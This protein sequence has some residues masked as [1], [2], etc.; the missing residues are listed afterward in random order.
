MGLE[1]IERLCASMSIKDREGPV[2]TLNAG[3]KMGGAQKMALCLAGKILSPDL[4]NMDAFRSLIARIWKVRG[5]VEI[6]VI[7]NNVYAFHFQLSEDRRKVFASGP[8]KFDD[9]LIVLEE[10]T[11]TRSI[12]GLKFD[13][14]D[15]W[16]QIS[17]LPLLCMT[18]EIAKFLG[19][20]VGEVRE[21]DSR[22]MGDCLGK[23]V[24]VR[25]A[26][27]I[28]KPLRRFLRVDVL[29]DGEETIMPSF[30]FRCGLL[31]HTVRGCP[32]GDC[33]SPINSKD[34]QYGVWMRAVAPAK[35]VGN[36]EWNPWHNLGNFRRQNYGLEG[37]RGQNHWRPNSGERPRS[38]GMAARL[39]SERKVKS[40]DG[41]S[42]RG[43]ISGSGKGKSVMSEEMRVNGLDKDALA[44]TDDGLGPNGI[45]VFGSSIDKANSGGPT[46]VEMSGL[47]DR[48][49]L[50]HYGPAN[51][52]FE[53]IIS[54][55]VTNTTGVAECIGPPSVVDVHA[56]RLVVR[57]GE[58][59]SGKKQ[60]DRIRGVWRSHT[61]MLHVE[62]GRR[63]DCRVFHG[64]E[65]ETQG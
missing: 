63:G 29:S 35:P 2:R 46:N 19:G 33:H 57:G 64:W 50:G 52:M 12:K 7:T 40:G 24:R 56:R 34:L 62:K 11:G 23:F 54:G 58:W 27:D 59:V 28:T 61:R 42:N 49:S 13:K 10:P 45:F 16:V 41:N 1:E 43:D 51:N 30:C 60:Q 22:P 53:G 5:G 18:R 65:Q 32:D 15:F 9:S 26:V 37:G 6:E 38:Q 3:L 4:V 21:V 25:V 31:G 17:N 20:I 48:L 36:R 44:V 8:W 14:V 55:S 47:V 39:V